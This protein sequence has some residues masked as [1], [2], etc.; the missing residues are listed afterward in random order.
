MLFSIL[1]LAGL[2]CVDLSAKLGFVFETKL[3]RPLSGSTARRIEKDL[4]KSNIF[5][6]SPAESAIIY[7]S[8]SGM[9]NMRLKEDGERR[10]EHLGVKLGNNLMGR[11]LVNVT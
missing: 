9:S 5:I 3:R 2:K 8:G 10:F 11:R 4:K 1:D 7:G 6:L